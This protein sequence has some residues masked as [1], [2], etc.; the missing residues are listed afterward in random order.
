MRW[1]TAALVGLFVL[2]QYPLWVGKGG[3]LKV[4]DYDHQL[5]QQREAN[6]RLQRPRRRSPRSQAGLRGDRGACPL[7]TRD[8]QAGRGVRADPGTGRR[9]QGGTVAAK[10]DNE[11]V[12]F[13]RQR[14][15]LN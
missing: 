2:L 3:W 4:W 8:D 1:L 13:C 10:T 9:R 5:A 15:A 11:A 7:R 6:H 12:S 14:G